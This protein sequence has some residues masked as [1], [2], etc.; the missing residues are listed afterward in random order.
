VSS[1]VERLRLAAGALNDA[2]RR[3]C[4]EPGGP[5][6]AWVD[7]Q[8]Q[9]LLAMADVAEHQE[10]LITGVVGGIRAAADQELA[11]QRIIT[12]QA[13]LALES[14]RDAAS[15]LEF[16]KGRVASQ[17]I[18]RV[19]PDMIEGVR[20]ALVI[21]ERRHNRRSEW[22]RALTAAALMLLLTAAG[23]VSGT[24]HDRDLSSRLEAM[25]S[26][27]QRCRDTSRWTDEAGH[28]LCQLD[29][30]LRD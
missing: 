10:H 14:A 27:I 29:I 18:E 30:F 2:A 24:R 6:G 13:Q 21:R 4:I 25:G 20:N 15:K 23:Y 5:L 12:E 1:Q 22:L 19:V 9:A 28:R 7:A 26:A 3:E 11:R 8:H 17:M 16:E